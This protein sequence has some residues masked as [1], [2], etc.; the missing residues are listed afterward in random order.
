MQITE[1]QFER[2]IQVIPEDLYE[3]ITSAEFTAKADKIVEENKLDDRQADILRNALGMVFMGFIPKNAL[4]QQL[5]ENVFGNKDTLVPV[6]E[7]VE[8]D[9]LAPFGE[10][11]WENRPQELQKKE[12]ELFKD[13][14]PDVPEEVQPPADNP[15]FSVRDIGET[16]QRPQATYTPKPST[17]PVQPKMHP[18]AMDKSPGSEKPTVIHTYTP[19]EEVASKSGYPGGLV[20]PSFYEEP[21]S[22]DEPE[23][24]PRANLEI[25][26]GQ[27]SEPI[28][29][30]R[31]VRVGKEEA[32]IVHYTAPQTTDPFAGKPTPPAPATSKIET[33]PEANIVDLKD[34]PK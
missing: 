23:G 34:L 6:M 16:P 9:V 29:E 26:G 10:D 25:G 13:D 1:E 20:R 28:T 17:A 5:L 30:P 22:Y 21:Q 31:T 27:A 19:S 4:G 12:D 18:Q 33:V 7:A 24:P 2:R 8:K 3:Q 15:S 14:M 11:F 32:R